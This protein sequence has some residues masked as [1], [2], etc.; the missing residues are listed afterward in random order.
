MADTLREVA[1]AQGLPAVAR[2]EALASEGPVSPKLKAKA[3][4]NK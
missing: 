4:G 1:P 3:G 2:R